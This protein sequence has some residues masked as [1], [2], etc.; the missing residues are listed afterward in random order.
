MNGA[1]N[2]WSVSRYPSGTQIVKREGVA[3]IRLPHYH[4]GHLSADTDADAGRSDVA[5]ELCAWLNGGQDPWWLGFARRE[6]ADVVKLPHGCEITA[7]G[8]MVDR[9]TPPAWGDW[10]QDDSADA[11]IARGLL[12]DRIAG[13]SP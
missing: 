3:C 12:A 8:P 11:R 6:S 2:P 1:D 9:A 7:T 4:V 5:D 13:R 10:V